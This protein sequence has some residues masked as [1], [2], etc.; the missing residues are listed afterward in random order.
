ML[1]SDST[2]QKGKNDLTRSY[3][4]VNI[5]FLKFEKSTGLWLT[6]NYCSSLRVLKI[7]HMDFKIADKKLLRKTLESLHSLE[8]LLMSECDINGY[9]NSKQCEIEPV[10]MNSL[11][12]IHL[13]A[14]HLG[15]SYIHIPK[16]LFHLY[17]YSS[18]YF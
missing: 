14:T 1:D 18:F 8:T 6:S 15:V 2:L 4:Q 13:S 17:R 7:M 11:K 5:S 10:I 9:E 3:S 16:S 12:N